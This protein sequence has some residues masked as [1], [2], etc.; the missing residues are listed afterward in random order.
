MQQRA[1]EHEAGAD[2]GADPEHHQAAVAGRA[3]GVLAED[4]G[5]GVVGDE[6]R[7]RRGPS[8]RLAASG[9]SVQARLGASMT[10][11][12]AS[13]TPGLPTPMPSTGPVGHR[14]QR[15]GQL[16]HAGR[17]PASPDGAVERQLVAG[18]H[19][20]AR[21]ITAPV[22]RSVA[23]RSMPMTW[24]ESAARPTSV[25]G[26]PTRLSAGAPSSS[27]SPS[28][29]SSPTRS[30]T[31]TRVRPLARAR[32]ARLAGPSRNSCWSSR[33]RWWRRASSWR[34]LPWGRSCRPTGEVVG[35]VC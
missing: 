35:H 4:G 16:V 10:V 21:L 1:A 27:T 20:P 8:A 22:I 6:D 9:V 11:P 12:A 3:E 17:R 31:V 18:L 34:S 23:D 32:S 19:L 13:T 14:D 2:T 29:T 26:L 7:R 5:V 30:E 25:G 24:C 28:A 33:D 15:G